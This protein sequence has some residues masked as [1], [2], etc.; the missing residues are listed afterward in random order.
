MSVDPPNDPAGLQFGGTTALA[1]FAL[2]ACGESPQDDRVR[3]AVAWLE[4][5]D[6]RG[7]YALGLRAQ[8]WPLLPPDP[9][10][11]RAAARDRELLLAGLRQRLV[12]PYAEAN[13]FFGYGPGVPAYQYDHSVS[14]F[15]VLGLWAAAQ[16]GLEVD[17][18]T[19]RQMDR[20]WRSH[21]RPDGA[22][23]YVAEPFDEDPDGGGRHHRNGSPSG[24]G[25]ELLSM[26]AAGVASLYLTQEGLTT[27]ARC[28]GNAKDADV[29]AGL[30]WMGDHFDD[31]DANEWSRTW[32]YYTLFG[33]A[34]VGLASGY[35]Y[36]GT[37]DW[38]AW[39]A[40][41]L[42]GRQDRTGGWG[43][44]ANLLLAAG[45]D[46]IDSGGYDTAFALLFLSRGRAPV[47]FNKL[48]YDVAAAGRP[49]AVAARPS[50]ATGTSGRGTWPT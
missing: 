28:D 26:T 5:A 1:T 8:V 27:A 41:R 47:L 14:Q 25:G 18:K 3:A 17:A 42:L 48:Q 9:A 38:F 10:V 4:H 7:T 19:W 2:L 15:G 20:A 11:R 29:A 43:G 21:R 12:G 23:C 13:G 31:I 45:T 22:W 40:D 46:P 30:R 49:T 44:E 33:I 50:S 35:K 34:R 16:V 36:I 32:D 37:T 39:G 6:V 24:L